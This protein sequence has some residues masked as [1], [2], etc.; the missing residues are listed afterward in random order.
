[1]NSKDYICPICGSYYDGELCDEC[2]YEN[3]RE[4]RYKKKVSENKNHKK[5]E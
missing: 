3:E 1:M 2:G 4:L 5:E